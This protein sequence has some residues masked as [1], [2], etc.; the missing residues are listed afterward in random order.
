MMRT[1]KRLQG[2]G[3]FGRVGYAD[4]DVNPLEWT[5]ALGLAGR[6]IIPERDNDTFGIGSYYGLVSDNISGLTERLSDDYWGFEAYYN[7]EFTPWLHVTPN[8]QVTDPFLDAVDK[9]Y[10]LGFRAKLDL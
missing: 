1:G 7:I 10:V 5:F 4:G 2:V 8:F 9:A 6:G 3:V